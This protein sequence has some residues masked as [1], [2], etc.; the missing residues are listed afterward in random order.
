MRWLVVAVLV[1]CSS[2]SPRVDRPTASSGNAVDAAAAL[3]TKSE[4]ITLTVGAR[5]VPGTVVSPAAP[6]RWPAVVLLAGS[7]PTDRDW[8]SKLIATKNGSG[9]LLAEALAAHGS[10]VLRFDKAGSGENPG[11]PIAEWTFDTYRDES[12]AALAALRARPDVRKD[13]VFVAGHSEGGIHATRLVAVSGTDVAGVIYLASASRS[14]ADTMI[15]QIEASMRNPVAGLSKELVDADIATLRATLND[16]LAGK[17]V[18][19]AKASV[20]PPVQQLVAGIVAPETA[21]LTRGLLGFDNA[22]EAPKSVTVPVLI[23]NGGKDIQVDTELDAKPL[24][25]A[26]V[27]AKRD[28]TL[29][30]APDADHVLKNEPKTVVQIRADLQTAQDGY[31][32]DGRVLDAA[33]TA[34]IVTWLAARTR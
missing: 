30:I 21:G 13:K 23:V 25:A 28:A 22:K 19:P 18:D 10:V 2:S 4:A 32:A 7:G 17:T 31:N 5:S 15:T 3:A 26:F 9:K 29:T 34:G 24:H 6:G 8:N 1:A 16:F 12:V 27:A 11:P 20:L 33:L 14:M